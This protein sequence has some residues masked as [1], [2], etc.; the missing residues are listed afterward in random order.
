MAR[1]QRPFLASPPGGLWGRDHIPTV[2]HGLNDSNATISRLDTPP[3]AHRQ[4]RRG[5]TLNH[6]PLVR[7]GGTRVWTAATT[8]PTTPLRVTFTLVAVAATATC[9]SDQ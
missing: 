3:P 1:G 5:T 4:G 2:V 9:T 7:D 8:S 6:A